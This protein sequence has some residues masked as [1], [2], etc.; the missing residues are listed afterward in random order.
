MKALGDEAQEEDKDPLARYKI[1]Y[2]N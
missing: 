2:D 1:L